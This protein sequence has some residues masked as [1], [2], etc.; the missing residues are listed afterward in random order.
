MLGWA[1]F[2]WTLTQPNRPKSNV[3]NIY[4]NKKKINLY[5]V[6]NPNS[7]PSQIICPRVITNVV[8]IIKSL[9]SYH[10][11]RAE[12]VNHSLLHETQYLYKTA[13]QSDTQFMSEFHRQLTIHH[14]HFIVSFVLIQTGETNFFWSTDT[15]H[16]QTKTVYNTSKLDSCSQYYTMCTWLNYK[17]VNQTLI[18][19][20]DHQLGD[21]TWFVKK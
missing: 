21:E 2:K 12:I 20:C 13:V 6:L 5:T 9:L 16:H 1:F 10:S 19:R 7:N 14:L 15:R 8:I 17:V 3:I 11:D 4:I 18:L